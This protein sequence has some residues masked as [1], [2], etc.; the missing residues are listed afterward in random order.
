MSST[1]PSTPASATP[2]PRRA[3]LVRRFLRNR[4]GTLGGV[5]VLVA[6]VVAVGAPLLA[7]YPPDEQHAAWRLFPPNEYFWLGTD[8]FGRDILSRLLFGAQISLIV[9]VVSV[10]LALLLGATLGLV[11]G[12][13]GALLDGVIMRVMDVVFAFPSTLLAIGI[14]AVL[15]TSTT[16]AIL[17][18]GLVY[19]P[20]FARLARALVL[21]LKEMEFIQ[22]SRVLGV[23]DR[24][25]LARHI[26][27]NMLAP[28]IVQTTFNLSTAVL[29]E[30]ALSFLGLGTPPPAPSWG[31]M[32]SASRRFV[33]LDPWPAIWP[34]LAIM[35]L[36]LGVNLFGDGLRDV[37]DPRLRS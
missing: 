8:E 17:A 9:G 28:I 11:A 30:A 33:E 27:P 26:L 31:L 22:A 2:E 37:L 23:S 12:F 5:I 32:L 10:G 16:N 18:I 6:A 35:L 25:I 13:Y 34:G 15:G 20:S 24:R 14:M 29:T 1:L 4:I 7:P 19:S 36:V 3:G 21:G